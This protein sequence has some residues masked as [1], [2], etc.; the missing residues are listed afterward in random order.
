MRTLKLPF[1]IDSNGSLAIASTTR[2]IVEQQIVD[3]LMTNRFERTMRPEYGADVAG[4]LFSPVAELALNIKA[5]EVR[6]L[7][8]RQVVLADILNVTMSPAPGTVS[9]VRLDVVYSIRPN[10]EVFT[11][12]QTVTGLATEESF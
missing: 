3:L 1:Q 10:T 11:L 9:T 12:T 5:G 8:Q 6:A 4:F 7:L 2:E